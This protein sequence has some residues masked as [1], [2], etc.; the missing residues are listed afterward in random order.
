[1]PVAVLILVFNDNFHRFNPITPTPTPL[2]PLLFS[3]K[4]SQQTQQQVL[5]WQFKVHY[6]YKAKLKHFSKVEISN[7]L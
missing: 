3:S 2:V 4:N 7:Y 6:F 1:M 5:L